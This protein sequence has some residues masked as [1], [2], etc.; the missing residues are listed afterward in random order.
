MI[1]R[2]STD[3]NYIERKERV[4]HLG[5][6]VITIFVFR[7]SKDTELLCIFPDWNTTVSEG[8]LTMFCKRDGEVLP[9]IKQTNQRR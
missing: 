7:L 6:N 9:T 1:D 4:G 2:T 5:L 8:I 3:N